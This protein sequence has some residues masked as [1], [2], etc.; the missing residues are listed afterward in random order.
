MT[1]HRLWPFS[2]LLILVI[3]AVTDNLLRRQEN[4]ERIV[5][6]SVRP[7]FSP[8][9][10]IVPERIRRLELQ[11]GGGNRWT[12]VREGLS[13]R[14]PAYFNAFA[15]GDRI[16][17]LLSGLL[18]GV[19]T[20]VAVGDDHEARVPAR[21]SLSIHLFDSDGHLLLNCLVGRG[22]LGISASESY[23]RRADDDTLFHWHT[24]PWH[25]LDRGNPPMVDNRVV[26]HSLGHRIPTTITI[27]AATGL[28]IGLRQEQAPLQ[29]GDGSPIPMM[30]GNSN[31]WLARFDDG[32]EDTC[33][34]ESAAAYAAFV[35]SLTF[36]KLRDPSLLE[37]DGTE[38]IATISLT[39][40]EGAGDMLTLLRAG[41]ETLIY[42][43]MTRLL[44]S[45]DTAAA[46]LLI[47][48]RM[49]LMDNLPHPSP[50]RRAQGEK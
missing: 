9:L 43:R 42:N 28:S 10:E 44:A 21:R 20:V 18:S 40:D 22:V 49:A 17:R 12:Y 1:S 7:L 6:S 8:T 2:G 19:G 36:L 5:R 27:D 48:T 15:R 33:R 46:H 14:Y 50:Y 31:L 13:W 39:G 26:P 32:P 4:R 30:P 29:L 25:V 16:E 11:V 41:D 47:P 34:V 3:F 45:I 24:N 35:S 23:L 38:E 37:A